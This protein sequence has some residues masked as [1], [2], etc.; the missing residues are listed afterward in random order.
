M[1]E[2]KRK[3]QTKSS[4]AFLLTLNQIERFDKLREYL[5]S[6]NCFQYGIA[7]K[8]VAPTT[9]HKHVHIFIQFYKSCRLSIKKLEGAH[10]DK[11]RGTP[12]QNKKY[13]E[14]DGDIIWEA[15]EMK[16]KGFLTIEEIKLLTKK[17][18]EKLSVQYYNTV[19]KLNTLDS[20][21]LT[22]KKLYK[23]VKVY[24]ISGKSGI[25]KTT[26]ATYLIGKEIFNIVKYENGFWMGIGN[27]NIALYDDWR[28]THM[29]PSEFL[30]FIDY[31][32]Q[33][34]NIKGGFKLNNY[35][36]IIIT[37]IF[38]LQDIYKEIKGESREQWERRIKEIHLSIV[39]NKQRENQ[40]NRLFYLIK[41]Y[42]KLYIYK[43]IKNILNKK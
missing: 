18:R 20:N 6:L 33:I 19:E 3:S 36:M 43:L 5:I 35:K 30:N 16:T 34:M 31:N 32:R 15:G 2:N 25:G 10:V 28:D 17:E 39:Y 4:S 21:E 8:E 37:S 22:C 41:L 12:Q 29:R 40:I 14:K 1:F 42:I 38:R 7:C 13:I 11:C 27:A 26:F 23:Q 24:Y 9:N